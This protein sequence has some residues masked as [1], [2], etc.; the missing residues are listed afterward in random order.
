MLEDRTIDD[1]CIET[2]SYTKSLLDFNNPKLKKPNI[3]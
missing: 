1:K 2:F 3:K